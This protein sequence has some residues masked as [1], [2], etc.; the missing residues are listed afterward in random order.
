MSDKKF[1]QRKI[2][3]SSQ[4]LFFNHKQVEKKV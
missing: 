1:T 2:K 4:G 3:I